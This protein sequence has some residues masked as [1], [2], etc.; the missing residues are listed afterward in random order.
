MN[1]VIRRRKGVTLLA[2]LMFLLVAASFHSAADNDLGRLGSDRRQ[3]LPASVPSAD[4]CAACTLDG[5]L[6]ARLTMTSPVAL[7]T[8]AETVSISVPPAPY[9]SPRASVESRPPPTA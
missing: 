4:T 8:A 2:A 5:L 9:V 7:P 3:V 1:A 6:S